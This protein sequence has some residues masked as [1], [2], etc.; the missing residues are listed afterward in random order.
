MAAAVGAAQW[1]AI[2]LTAW[3][4]KT[5]TEN[6]Y[7]Q[8]LGGGLAAV[9]LLCVLVFSPP[10]FVLLGRLQAAAQVRP[11]LALAD[12][13]RRRMRGPVWMWRGLA[14]LGVGLVWAVLPTALHL[15]SYATSALMCTAIG[16]L[17]ALGAVRGRRKPYGR[18]GLWLRSVLGGAGLA[19]L[20]LG[21]LIG[22]SVTG[23]LREYE[24][25]KLTNAQLVGVWRGDGAELRLTADR[26][27]ELSDVPYAYVWERDEV[28]RCDGSGIWLPGTSG[29]G[30]RLEQGVEV[31]V[32]SCGDGVIWTVGGTAEHPE[33]Y[34]PFG[35]LDT[36]DVRIL[37]R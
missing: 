1:P 2:G 22:A 25:P 14:L 36:P 20:A 35:D 15:W 24:P 3:V 29:G 26:R 34:V 27:A 4:V 30:G 32:S 7:G 17:P 21:G 5:T 19:A 9:G 16:V 6:D 23:L 18:R 8:T 31:E 13:A 11:A 28:E 12:L 33:L 37:R 10:V